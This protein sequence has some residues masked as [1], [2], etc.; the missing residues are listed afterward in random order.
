MKLF[1]HVLFNTYVIYI[2]HTYLTDVSSTFFYACIRS[3]EHYILLCYL[4]KN[5]KQKCHQHLKDS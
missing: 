4:E 3:Y 1:G 5:K 2:I